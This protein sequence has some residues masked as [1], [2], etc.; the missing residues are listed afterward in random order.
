MKDLRVEVS[1]RRE[2]ERNYFDIGLP[3]EQELLSVTEMTMMLAAGM[4]LLIKAGHK[5]GDFKDY[6]MMEHVIDYMKSEFVSTDSFED[7]MFKPN[8]LR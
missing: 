2:D 1:W 8:T 7:A 5:K 6:E 3:K 4:S